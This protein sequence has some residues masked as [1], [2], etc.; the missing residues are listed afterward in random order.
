MVI[1]Q[2]AV[3]GVQESG[4]S[5]GR[6]ARA[7]GSRIGRLLR[8]GRG[9]TAPPAPVAGPVPADPDRPFLVVHDPLPAETV[10][11]ETPLLGRLGAEQRRA[12]AAALR[13]LMLARRGRYDAAETAF[14]EAAGRDPALDLASAAAFW[15]LPRGG[16]DAAV[17]AYE[18]AGRV[19]D[20]AVL[21]ATIRHR[22]APRALPRRPTRP[23]GADAPVPVP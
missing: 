15:E 22:F 8:R 20:A 4:A 12:E 1:S 14:A 5:V 6:V 7:V 11:E 18:R 2:P 9:G 21:G 17:R 23:A 16:Q 19:R 13:G 3:V 10:A